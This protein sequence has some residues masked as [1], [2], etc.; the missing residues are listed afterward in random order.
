MRVQTVHQA[1]PDVVQRRAEIWMQS[2]LTPHFVEAA[3]WLNAWCGM[4]DR[5]SVREGSVTG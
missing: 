2:D 4:A 5:I 1:L 3:A